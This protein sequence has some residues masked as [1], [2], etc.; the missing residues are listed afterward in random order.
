MIN[1]DE[2]F[3]KYIFKAIFNGFFLF[4]FLARLKM[5]KPIP[6]VYQEPDMAQDFCGMVLILNHVYHQVHG[7]F[8][9]Y[10]ILISFWCAI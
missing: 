9:D 4:L 6:I 7:T 8:L 5:C 3:L 1:K 2:I 10:C